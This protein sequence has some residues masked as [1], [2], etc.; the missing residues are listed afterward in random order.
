MTILTTGRL[1][2]RRPRAARGGF[3]L[4]ELILVMVI[5]AVAA[6]VAA[7]ALRLFLGGRALHQVAERLVSLGGYAATR[8]VAEGRVYR[9]EIDGRARVYRL[10]GRDDDEFAPLGQ[11]FGRDFSLPDGV[12]LDWL[13]APLTPGETGLPGR[14]APPAPGGAVAGEEVKWV[15]FYPDGR[16]DPFRLRLVGPRGEALVVA[17]PSPAAGLRLEE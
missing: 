9:L 1:T 14:P 6:T 12:V 2:D 17:C 8:A 3:T 15:H 16:I 11:D 5:A 13:E 7:P 10:Q 4:V